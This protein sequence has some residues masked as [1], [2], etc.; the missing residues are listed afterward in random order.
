M[1]FEATVSAEVADVAAGGL[2]SA[3]DRME[4]LL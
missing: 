3:F 1:R 2:A 4:E